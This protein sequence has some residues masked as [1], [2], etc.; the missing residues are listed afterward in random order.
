MSGKKK[1]T[2]IAENLKRLKENKHLSQSDLCEKTGLAYHT[3]AKIEAG[4]TPD[5]R[6]STLKKIAKALDVSI[7][8]LVGGNE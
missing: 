2:N 4:S 8:V 1:A 6:I 5:P 7:D 3:I